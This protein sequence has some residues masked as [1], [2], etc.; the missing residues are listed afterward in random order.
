[1]ILRN[2]NSE[3]RGNLDRDCPCRNA[4][5]EGSGTVH[6][7]ASEMFCRRLKTVIARSFSTSGYDTGA[8]MV[9]FFSKLFS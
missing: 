1:M 8:L 9:E 6:Q 4:L 2:R 3:E 5:D 7:L